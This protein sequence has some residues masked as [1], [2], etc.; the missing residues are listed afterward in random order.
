M[1]KT[2][3][4][5]ATALLLCA[6]A[7]AQEHLI[8]LPKAVRTL[9]FDNCT[10]HIVPDTV[11]GY[12]GGEMS[13]GGGIRVR[14][15]EMTFS[16]N[17]RTVRLHL[18]PN[19]VTRIAA[20]GNSEVTL[21]GSFRF[22]GTLE[23]AGDDVATITLMGNADTLFAENLMVALEDAAHIN[24]HSL[25]QVNTYDVKVE[26][27]SLLKV[28]LFEPRGNGRF[29]NTQYATITVAHRLE[30][31]HGE[32]PG[33]EEMEAFWSG[34]EN[35]ELV[36]KLM[37]LDSEGLSDL[38]RTIR[39]RRGKSHNWSSGIDFA[40][41]FHNWGSDRFNGLAGT[42]GDAAVRTSFNH[43]L[44]TFNYPVLHSRRVALYAG[45]GMEWDKYKF[46]RGDIHFDLTAEP[47]HLYNGTEANSE[48]RLLTRYII[49]PV[50]VRIALGSHWKI[51]LAAI[52]GLHWSGSH[53]GLRRDI[54]SGDDETNIKDFS[55][56]PYINPYKLDARIMVQYRSVGVFFQASMLSAFKSS[57]DELFPVKFGII[58]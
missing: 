58:L 4:L 12:E 10:A 24:A 7:T 44:L 20:T 15:S 2:T 6:T 13:S 34:D 9:V 37:D 45:L 46:H 5:F 50:E 38:V 49:L 52:P 30:P 17:S 22:P 42:D 28:F 36:D 48:S 1:K 54:S 23:L 33:S 53:T 11:C 3:I 41:G 14:G 16:E 27:F 8:P 43:I 19:A 47:Y 39:K 31:G 56:N 51:G 57:C 21:L 32:T 18:D 25:L 26:D 40:W 29:D 35:V 55:V